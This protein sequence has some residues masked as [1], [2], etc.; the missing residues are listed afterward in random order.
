VWITAV[1]K[2]FAGGAFFM[3]KKRNEQLKRSAPSS[4]WI[5]K[6][7]LISLMV[8]LVG[9]VGAILLTHRTTETQKVATAKYSSSNYGVSVGKVVPDFTFRLADGKQVSLASL[10]GKPTLLYFVTTWCSS[11]VAGTHTLVE[12][13]SALYKYGIRIVEL[14]LYNDLGYPGPPINVLQNFS[15]PKA[16]VDS[17]MW[18]WGYAS[19][20]MSYA[21]DP[22][23]DLDIYYLLNS[24]GKVMLV[25]SS[26]SVT[27]SQL[28]A[29]AKYMNS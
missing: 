19:Q 6:A 20:S 28:L 3:S 11:C 9:L 2:S 22:H 18:Q 21:F 26:P 1:A 24:D 15:G 23:G 25:G 14:E 16:I 10:K 5:P 8:I 12:N 13:F 29:A 7:I 4:S 17:S 27:I